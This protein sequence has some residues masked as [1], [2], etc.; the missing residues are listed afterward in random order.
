MP[1]WLPS[2]F[3]PQFPRFFQFPLRPRG[4]LSPRWPIGLV[5]HVFFLVIV[6]LV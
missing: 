1:A 4:T 2:R 3:Q 6:T 5:V